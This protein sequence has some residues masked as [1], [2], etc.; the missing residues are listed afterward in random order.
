[1]IHDIGGE[2]KMFILHVEVLPFVNRKILAHYLEVIS[3]LEKQLKD[4]GQDHIETWV[5]TDDQIRFAE[6]YGFRLTGEEITINGQRNF[7]PI[8][9]M[10]KEI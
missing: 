7:Q 10:M 9:Q 6:F 3:A 1:M 2:G 4:R 8:Y 5:L